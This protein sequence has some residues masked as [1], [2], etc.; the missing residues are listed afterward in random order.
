MILEHT[1]D[2]ICRSMGLRSFREPHGSEAVLRLLL[3][4]SQSPEGEQV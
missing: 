2:A 3:Q 1:P 4:P